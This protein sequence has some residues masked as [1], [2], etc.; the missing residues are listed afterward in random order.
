M[1]VGPTSL[2]ERFASMKPFGPSFEWET[3]PVSLFVGFSLWKAKPRAIIDFICST[4]V[5]QSR[6]ILADPHFTP[7]N[8]FQLPRISKEDV[9]RGYY[10]DLFTD[11]ISGLVQA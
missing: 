7:E 2:L 6:Y 8:L 1:K 3:T 10:I 11:P 4:I 9:E 5:D